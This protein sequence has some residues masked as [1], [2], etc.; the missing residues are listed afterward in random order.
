[1]NCQVSMFFLSD[2]ASGRLNLI[3]NWDDFSF[4]WS[5]ITPMLSTGFLIGTILAIFDPQLNPMFLMKFSVNWP[6]SSGVE[7]KNKFSRWP[8]RR[9]YRISIGRIKPF[10]IYKSSPCFLP[11]FKSF[12][13]SVQEKKRKI[14]FQDGHPRRLYWISDRNNFS[15]LNSETTVMLPTKFQDNKLF[16]SGEGA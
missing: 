10:L 1:M 14:D 5:T 9:P 3:S 13:L 8:P 11:S 2:W 6:F 7:A 16:G 15:Y 12:S 4:F